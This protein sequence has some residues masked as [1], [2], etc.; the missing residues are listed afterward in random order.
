LACA[1]PDD[2]TTIVTDSSCNVSEL[3]APCNA[4]GVTDDA[5]PEKGTVA[6]VYDCHSL[7]VWRSLRRLGVADAEVAD[8]VQDVFLVVQRRLADFERRSSLKTW[9]FGIAMRVA[10]DYTRRSPRRREETIADIPMQAAGPSPAEH[11]ARSEA[12]E[13]LYALLQELTPDQRAAFIL[14]ELE[15]MSVTEIAAALDASVH[16]VTSR[17]K[18]ARRRFEQGLLRHRTRDQWRIR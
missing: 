5:Q 17:L 10:S 16:T 1:R 6:S 18:T 11:A 4:K 8:A 13:L 3:V 15:Q 9:L 14:A 2:E 12:V 7:F